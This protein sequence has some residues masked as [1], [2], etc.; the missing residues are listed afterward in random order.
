[1]AKIS[2]IPSGSIRRDLF[3]NDV[4]IKRFIVM[5][6]V[7]S[8]SVSAAV[9]QQNRAIVGTMASEIG[10]PRVLVSLNTKSISELTAHLHPKTRVL[11]L[12]LS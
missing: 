1:M 10:K 11:L 4:R 2:R 8:L 7:V 3:N 9:G 5:M 12:R 6:V